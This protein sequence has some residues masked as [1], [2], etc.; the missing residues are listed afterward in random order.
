MVILAIIAQYFLN[1]TRFGV[2]VLAIGGSEQSARL[3][4]VDI[5]RYKAIVYIVSGFLSAV[6]ALVLC[7]RLRSAYPGAGQGYELNVI[8]AT[9]IGG[10]DLMGGSGT[11]LGAIAGALTIGI[12]QNGLNLLGV[13]PFMQQ[14]ATGLLIVIAVLGNQVRGSQFL[15]QLRERLPSAQP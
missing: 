3:A 12:I 7:A 13:A 14:I 11:V 15:A 8:A 6:G 2:R 5:A 1:R 9:V 10:I 4:G